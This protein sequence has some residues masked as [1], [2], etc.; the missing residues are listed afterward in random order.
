M[1]TSPPAPDAEDLVVISAGDVSFHRDERN[2]VIM[3][4]AGAEY[5]VARILALFPLTSPDRLLSL[6]DR[7]G[8]EVGVLD[9][10]DG[11]DEE[12]RR[13]AARELDLSYFLPCITDIDSIVEA[14]G[15]VIWD[16]TTDRGPRVF[17][18]REIRSNLR[19]LPGDRIIVCDVDGNRYDIPE[20]G[21]LPAP[22]RRLVEPF[23]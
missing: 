17:E 4:W 11:L 5:A 6:R 22:A 10:L 13:I 15:L 12:A 9:G 1:N 16:V 8:R 19:R 21:G 20:L 2:D 18:V 3:T 7:D 23:L 14:R